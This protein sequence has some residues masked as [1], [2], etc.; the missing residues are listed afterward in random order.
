MT[1]KYQYYQQ[2]V[3]QSSCVDDE[4][5]KSTIHY[6]LNITITLLSTSQ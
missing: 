5:R 6:L 2:R 4:L 3:E 1:D